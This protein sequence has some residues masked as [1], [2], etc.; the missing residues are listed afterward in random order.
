MGALENE[1][2]RSRSRR[3][4]NFTTGLIDIVRINF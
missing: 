4:E 2:F 1:N 3:E